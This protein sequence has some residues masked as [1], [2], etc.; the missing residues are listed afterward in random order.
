MPSSS[1]A[2]AINAYALITHDRDFSKV[3]GMRSL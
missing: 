3:R 1:P 2:L